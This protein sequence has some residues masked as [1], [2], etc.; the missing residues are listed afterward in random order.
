[1]NSPMYLVGMLTMLALLLGHFLGYFKG[2]GPGLAF[3]FGISLLTVEWVFE[4]SRYI[5]HKWKNR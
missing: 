2:A 4:V 5:G 1:M 3:I